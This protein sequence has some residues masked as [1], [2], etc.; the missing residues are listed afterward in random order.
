M[1][2]VYAWVLL[3]VPLLFHEPFLRGVVLPLL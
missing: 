3:P 1:L 2:W